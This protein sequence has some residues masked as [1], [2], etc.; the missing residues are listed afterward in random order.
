MPSPKSATTGGTNGKPIVEDRLGF[1]DECYIQHGDLICPF[2]DHVLVLEGG[3]CNLGDQ[4]EV[5]KA[6]IVGSTNEAD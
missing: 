1:R 4:C 2:C 3:T 6:T 5:C